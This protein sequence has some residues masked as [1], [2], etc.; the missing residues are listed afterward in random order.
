ME[1]KIIKGKHHFVH[2]QDG[3]HGHY[4]DIAYY[5][6]DEG[7]I[8]V[9]ARYGYRWATDT[10]RPDSIG[11]SPGR[12]LLLYSGNSNEDASK[13]VRKRTNKL[14][15]SQYQIMRDTSIG[16][17]KDKVMKTLAYA[18]KK[19]ADGQQKNTH[20]Q[21]VLTKANKLRIKRD[22]DKRFSNLEL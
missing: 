8:Q 5:E 1:Y 14:S 4:Y 10:S 18:A 13:I 12:V 19:M 7:H 6:D 21:I 15:I 22:K 2:Q 20:G 17:S 16:S 11:K 3:M 9:W